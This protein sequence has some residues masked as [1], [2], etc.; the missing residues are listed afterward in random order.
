MAK[1]KGYY[2]AANTSGGFLSLFGEIFAPHGLSRLY[3]LKGGPGTGKSTF[4]Y[5]IGKAAAER[6]LETEYYY[7]SA[8]TGSLDGVKIPSLGVAVADGTPPHAIE[9]RYPGACEK[10]INLG[11]NFDETALRGNRAEIERLTD[12][13]TACYGRGARFLA[14]AGET[15]LL[16]METASQ[17]FDFEKAGKAVRRILSQAKPAGGGCTER[18]ISALGTG[19]A[20][21]IC[22]A[23]EEGE[24]TVLVSGKYG[25]ERLFLSVLAQEAENG[26][27]TCVRFPDV[28]LRER[29]EGIYIKEI[30]TRFTASEEAEDE[31]NAGRFVRCEVLAENRGKLRFAEKCREALLQGAFSELAKMGGAHGELEKYYVAAMDFGKSGEMLERVKA[32]IFG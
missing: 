10:I 32:E 18:Y 21:H 14:A 2:A 8:D 27:Y 24:R 3:I 29:T 5:S 1:S 30:G 23:P 9:P 22:N 19:G 7:C 4:M 26:G 13:C 15:E 20:A 17:A 16:Y 11:A 6:G 31:I 12:E 28:L 25:A